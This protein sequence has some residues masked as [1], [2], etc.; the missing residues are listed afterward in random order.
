MEIEF[1]GTGGSTTT[2][3]FGCLCERCELARSGGLPHSRLGPSIFIHGPDILIDTPEEIS[4]QLARSSVS[5]IRACFYSHWHPDHVM[6]RRIWEF[7]KTLRTWPIPEQNDRTHIYLPFGVAADFKS[8]Y[9][10]WDY[11]CQLEQSGLIKLTVLSERESVTI[12]GYSVEPFV[13]GEPGMYGFSISGNNRR[14]IVI[15]DE[16]FCWEVP[17]HLKG[18]VDVAV[19]PTGV[20]EH[21]PISGVRLIDRL[22]PVLA[23][24][25]T[26]KQTLEVCHSLSPSRVYLTHIEEVDPV[27]YDELLRLSTKISSKDQSIVF[28]FDTLRVIV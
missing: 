22:H 5:N 7:K 13:L 26:F 21:H 9:D 12:N 15:P 16:L 2:P 3:R 1:L 17:P 10:L 19:L 25:A 8:R 23:R 27:S 14:A 24:E 6:G 20:F 18:L 4:V 28:A 11:F